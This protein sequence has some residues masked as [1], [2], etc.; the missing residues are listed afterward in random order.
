MINRLV[1]YWVYGGF[2][3][4]FLLLGLMPTFAHLWDGALI[5]VYLQL[6]IYMFHQLEEH[7]DNHFR[8][9]INQHLAGGRDVLSKTAI[10]VINVPGVWGVNLLSILLAYGVHIGFGLIGVYLTFLN[11]LI[12]IAQA[13]RLRCYNPGLVTAIFLFLPV[14]GLGLWAIERTGEVGAGY[15]YLGLGSAVAIHVAIIVYVV[16]NILRLR[17]LKS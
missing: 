10:F 7:D 12:H 14:G 9:F 6:P 4:A 1:S 5:L 15:H 16:R 11:G 13:I 17:A 8:D 2:L 3:A